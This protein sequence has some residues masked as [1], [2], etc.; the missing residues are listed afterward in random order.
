M[1]FAYGVIDGFHV[2]MFP[3]YGC[4]CGSGRGGYTRT[5]LDAVKMQSIR[6]IVMK[7]YG[8]GENEKLNMHLW[9]GCKEKKKGGPGIP[10]EIPGR[11]D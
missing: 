1:L 5:P 11:T 10:I 8:K 6:S 9:Q 2:T 7:M 4:V 3:L